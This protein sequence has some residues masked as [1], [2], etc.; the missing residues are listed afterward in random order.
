MESFETLNTIYTTLFPS[1]IANPPTR[2]T[3]ACSSTLLPPSVLVSLSAVLEME[4]PV[5]RRL[6]LHVQSRSYS[7]PSNIG[8][9]SQAISAPLTSKDA[10][11]DGDGVGV[12]EVVHVA[13]Q[14]PLVPGTMELLQGTLVA[15]A[16]LS[17]Q[18]LWR[19]GQ[20]RAVDWWTHGIAYLPRQDKTDDD[21]KRVGV[22]REV[23]QAAH[24]HLQKK[25]DD[26]DDDEVDNEHSAETVD[27]WDSQHNRYHHH[28]FNKSI[29][30]PSGTHLHPLPNLAILDNQQRDMPPLMRGDL[31]PIPPLLIAEVESLP[32]DAPIEWHSLGLASLPTSPPR[33]VTHTAGLGW[34]K[35]S[36]CTL[37]GRSLR[38]G[39]T[40]DTDVEDEGR[41]IQRQRPPPKKTMT[42]HIFTTFQVLSSIP[43]SQADSHLE[44]DSLLAN[45][46]S[47]S[48]PSD[49]QLT[50]IRILQSTA[51]IAGPQGQTRLSRVM[52]DGTFDSCIRIPCHA[53]WGAS[54]D[55]GGL[56]RLC[57]ALTVRMEVATEVT[58]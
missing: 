41:D 40:S 48:L 42:G 38:L 17:L 19:V 26:L 54:S 9:Y 52:T 18:H 31:N 10:R 44:L 24:M 4:V 51:Y 55:M 11:G 33:L 47:L 3:I 20:D 53:L 16:V 12:A 46:A 57:L 37:E 56:E 15:Q 25:S 43:D 7:T 28:G 27:L 45:A 5:E 13:G 49:A 8:P 30:K 23:W 36:Q 22:V 14:I 50:S 21:E 2:V 1:T 35:I 32:R 39:T 6:G 29:P 58:G 34:V